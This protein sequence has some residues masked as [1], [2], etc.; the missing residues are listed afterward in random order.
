MHS[1]RKPYEPRAFTLIELL[2]VIAI[3]AILAGMLLPALGKSKEKGRKTAC[4]NN[5]RQIGIAMQLY[6]EDSNQ[7]VPRGN[8]PYW[9]QVFIPYLSAST[10]KQDQVGKVSVYTCP[11]YPDRRQ[12]LCYVINA[13]Q[14]SSLL[15]KTGSELVGLQKISRIQMPTETAYLADNENGSWRPIFTKTNFLGDISMNDIWSPSHLPY[16]STAANAPLNPERRIAAKRH[17]LGSNLLYFDSHVA[18]KPA[19]KMTIEDWREQKY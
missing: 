14:F 12:V 6:F 5:L 16:N 18:W 9:W 4:F 11:S 17:A 8:D 10:A 3:I 13:W 15:D 2:V 7:L 1:T 19:R